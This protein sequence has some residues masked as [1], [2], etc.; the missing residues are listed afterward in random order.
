MQKTIETRYRS[1]A[2]C[3]LLAFVCLLSGCAS[4]STKPIVD[5][6][7]KHVAGSVA[8]L[9]QVTLGGVKQWI[10]IRGRNASSPLVLKLHGGPGQAEMATV[11]FN[12][13]LEQDFLIVEWDQRGAGKSADVPAAGLTMEQIVSDTIELSQYL[14]KRFNQD[15]LTLVGHSWGSAVGL[16]AVDHA[17]RLYRA[18]VSTGQMTSFSN[19]TS[20]GYQALLEHAGRSSD[21]ALEAEINA[22]GEPPYVGPEGKSK[23]AKYVGLLEKYGSLWHAEP[24]FNPVR[25]MIAAEEY[26]WPEK[27]SFNRAAETSFEALLPD[28][29]KLDMARLVPRVEVPVY[30]AVGRHDLLA[31]PSL[32]FAYFSRLTAPKKEWI[33]FE[34]SAH[35][36][37]WEEPGE[38]HGLLMRVLRES[39]SAPG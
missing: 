11:Q 23:R 16:Q 1:F 30:F 24:G 34:K 33:W 27:L 18:F 35:F 29:L 5:I 10:L 14:L 2:A 9:E 28:L 6:D 20:A 17:P 4:T 39:G 25:W 7:G 36:P 32:A 38:F 15:R 3:C 8:T 13:L 21:K 31:S 22:L 37:Q 26:S 12:N 19:A